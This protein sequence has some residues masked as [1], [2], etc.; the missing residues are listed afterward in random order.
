MNNVYYGLALVD[1]R[2]K[3]IRSGSNGYSVKISRLKYVALP[4]IIDDKN[5]NFHFYK[6]ITKHG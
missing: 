2:T 5:I 3:F 4:V 1:L 6:N